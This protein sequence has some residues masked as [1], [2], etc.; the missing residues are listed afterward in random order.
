MKRPI[1]L[2]LACALLLSGC[3]HQSTSDS[4]VP[5]QIDNHPTQA[6]SDVSE[7]PE[8]S[9][10]APITIGKEDVPNFSS[11]SD[12]QLLRYV[13][14]SIYADLV[15]SLDDDHFVQNISAVYV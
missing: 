10:N 5:P 7:Q 4:S 6:I 3:G 13:E 12:P 2:A 15:N 1:S 14:D 8:P 11:L 9:K